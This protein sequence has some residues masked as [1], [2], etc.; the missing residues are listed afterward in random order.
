MG[1]YLPNSNAHATSAVASTS[2]VAGGCDC[3][4]SLT[5]ARNSRRLLLLNL[6]TTTL[7]GDWR[8]SFPASDAVAV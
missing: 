7:R 4:V 3:E 2:E 5:P 1:Q 6:V 8:V